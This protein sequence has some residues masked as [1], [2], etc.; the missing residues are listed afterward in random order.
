MVKRFVVLALVCISFAA[1]A[2][3]LIASKAVVATANHDATEAALEVLRAG[4]NAFDAAVTA[5]LVLGVS[6]PQSSG[7]GGG[8]FAT[9]YDAKTKQVRCLDFRERAPILAHRDLYIRE[10]VAKPELSQTGALSVAVPGQAAGLFELHKKYGKKPFASLVDP[11]VKLAQNGVRVSAHLSAAFTRYSETLARFES[12][13]SAWAKGGKFPE[14]GAKWV[15]PELAKT[16]KRYGAQGPNGFYKG[17]VARKITE[18]VVAQGGILSLLD[19]AEY[20]VKWREPVTTKYRSYDV[21]SM[22]PPSSGGV[23]LAEMLN[24]LETRDVKTLGY[25]SP[26]LLHFLIETMRRAYADRATY[27][28]DPG[29]VAVPVQ[30]LVSKEYAKQLSASIDPKLASKSDK[31]GPGKPEGSKESTQTTHFS[32]IDADG[33]A[34]AITTTVNGPFGSSLVV[35]GTGVLLNDQMDDFAIAPGVPNLFGL[36]GGEANSVA[37]R[38]TPLSSMAPTIVLKDGALRWVIG[39]PG[40]ATIITQVLLALVN[41][42]DFESDTFQAIALPRIHM[43]W[44]PDVVQIERFA[45]DPL[46]QKALADLGH[47]FKVQDAWGNAQIVGVLP[48]GRRV[49]ASDPRGDGLTLGY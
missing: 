26:V 30:G 35:E 42:I 32:I 1:E 16:L 7:L 48:D 2:G 27:L 40:G 4:G 25:H 20:Q 44:K 17:E 9:I 28:G 41:L 18:G 14:T 8:G 6:E 36:V 29:F 23:H 38:K 31:V 22:P 43:Q 11:A 24:M 37:P 47:T 21:F 10:G 46:T 33:N 34:V 15:Q 5:A 13:K 45:L 49:G 39:S 19:M 12:T 3:E